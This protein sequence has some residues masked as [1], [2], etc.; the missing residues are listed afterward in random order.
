MTT[1]TA[2]RGHRLW[3]PLT[4]ALLAAGG[5]ATVRLQPELERNLKDW[6]TAVIAILAVLLGIIWFFAFS[7]VHWKVRLLAAVVLTFVS[8]EATQLLGVDGTRDGT[9]LPRITWRWH[10]ARRSEPLPTVMPIL[11]PSA[12]PADL[13]EV[14]GFFGPARDGVV[15]GARLATDWAASPPRELWRQTIGSGWSA[16]AVVGSRA[17][18]QEQRGED[19]VVTAYDLRSGQLL[20]LHADHTRF[21]QWQGGE[22]PRATPSVAGESVFSYGATGLLQCLDIA[23]GKPRWAHEILAE[24]KVEN[25]TWGVSCSPL[26]FEDKVVVT[27]GGNA[28]PTLLAFQR[29]TGAPLWKAGTDKASYASPILATLAGRRVILSN[30]AA[31]FTAH[32]PATGEVLLSLGWSDGKWPIA[33]QPVVLPGDRVFLSAGY[34]T[35]CL[36][37]KVDAA[38]EGKLTATT[39][40]KS[41]RMKTQFNSAAL[42]GEYLYGL[43]DGLFACVAVADGRR[44]WK[45]G[46]F[47]SGQSLL[48]DDLAIIQS[49][50]GAVVLAQASPD[51]YRELGRLAALSSKTWNNPTLAGRYLLVR[52]DHE[53]VCYELPLQP[54]AA[55]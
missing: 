46:R 20:W 23:T 1:T 47:G 12:P 8:Y 5:I 18:T 55:H 49:E 40:W 11:P 32:D 41:N 24:N 33:S 54:G 25:L 31:T 37:L 52:N 36:M 53:A 21:F 19:E 22:G 27:G 35:G 43:D 44:V 26:V 34:G 16:F 29:D 30:N 9:G 13:A 2:P 48:A 45:D 17:F 6:L 38:P 3:F 15:T 51:G 7:R 39:L 10:T 50:P 14:P 4:V 42:R 28:A